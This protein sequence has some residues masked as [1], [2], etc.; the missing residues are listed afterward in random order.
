MIRAFYKLA[1]IAFILSGAS[2]VSMNSDDFVPKSITQ[3]NNDQGFQGSINVQAVVPDSTRSKIPDPVFA[4]GS[5]ISYGK[6]YWNDEYKRY[7]VSGNTL[8]RVS[9]YNS[10][11]LREALEKT[12]GKTGLF[13]RIEQNNADYVLDV[14]IL[15]SFRSPKAATVSNEMFITSIWRLTRVKDGKVII[16]AFVNGHGKWAGSIEKATQDMI[17]NGLVV[18]TD[19]SRPLTAMNVASDWPSMGSV[20]TEGYSKFKENWGLLQKGMTE[21]NVRKLITSIP[22]RSDCIN[23]FYYDISPGQWYELKLNNYFMGAVPTG[24]NTQKVALS[25]RP[26]GIHEISFDLFDDGMNIKSSQVAVSIESILDETFEPLFPFYNLTF[27]K[28]I[29]EN[30]ELRK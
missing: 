20:I 25:F 6:F 29:L 2:C 26:A 8:S 22:K 19:K 23:R 30:W 1:I 18:L 12:I 16:C 13:Q 3:V 9:M 5:D 21:Q 17:Q 15:D 7:E 10:G 28:G 4:R 27:V 11:I 14:W 24:W